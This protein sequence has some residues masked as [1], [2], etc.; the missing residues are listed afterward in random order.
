MNQVVDRNLSFLALWYT[1]LWKPS[2]AMFF[3]LQWSQC[4]CHC[5]QSHCHFHCH[6]PCRPWGP[7]KVEINRS[8]AST[9][10]FIEQQSQ[11]SYNFYS[12]GPCHC[13]C[14]CPCQGY[15]H[16]HY[17]V[18]TGYQLVKLGLEPSV[19]THSSIGFGIV[20]MSLSPI[21][22]DEVMFVIWRRTTSL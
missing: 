11:D 12:H 6:F 19:Q 18:S 9:D 15:C 17:G 21:Q 10:R 14:Q 4:H 22:G 2:F 3:S 8:T 5:Q 7:P 16:C 13:H 20:E 1:F